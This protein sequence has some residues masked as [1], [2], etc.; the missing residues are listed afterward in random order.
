MF[1]GIHV[2]SYNGETH[3]SFR[4]ADLAYTTAMPHNGD[5]AADHLARLKDEPVG[6]EVVFDEE[7]HSP[8]V[9]RLLAP[10]L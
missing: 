9:M 8:S 7:P 4:A 10:V 2:T 6:F 1:V 3:N 5:E